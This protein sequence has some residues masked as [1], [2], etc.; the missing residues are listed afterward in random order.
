MVHDEEGYIRCIRMIGEDSQRVVEDRIW[1]WC[2]R[3]EEGQLLMQAVDGEIW[4]G[5]P[6]PFG[7]DVIRR[8]E[9]LGL[10]PI[11]GV[12]ASDGW[13]ILSLNGDLERLPPVEDSK[14]MQGGDLLVSDSVS[15]LVSASRD[16]LLKWWEAPELALRRRRRIQSEVAQARED[17]DWEN[18][19]TVFTA[20]RHAEENGQLSR[21]AEL[22]QKLGRTDDVRRILKMKR[23]E[24]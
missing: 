7:W 16:G 2:S 3:L 22:Y 11:E 19:K 5:I 10:E 17:L 1:S 20:A 6:H 13:W 24:A 9:T 8:I 23:E 4:E 12:I 15:T 21:A 14:V 18:R